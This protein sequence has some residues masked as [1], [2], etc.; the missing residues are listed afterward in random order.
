MVY[1]QATV[2]LLKNALYNYG[3]LSTI[4]AVYNDFFSYTGGV[5]HYVTGGL[6]GYHAVL[7]V[8][9]DDPG[10]YFIVKNSWGTWWGEAGYFK[11]AYSELDSVVGFGDYTI[12]YMGTAPTCSYSI[13]NLNPS[14]FP[15]AGGPGS[16]NVN[17]TTNCP[18][19]AS[20]NVSWIT[21]NSGAS[22]TGSGSVT[23]SV[24]QNT[25]DSRNGTLNI[26]GQTVHHRPGSRFAFLVPF[27]LARLSK[28]SVPPVGTEASG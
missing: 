3:P 19:T 28:A 9:Y 6:A 22:G 11:I 14:S 13:S 25:G 26:A 10:Q 27:L 12:A 17:A 20:S 1:G 8:G 16:V 7:L 18:W 24:S 21:I 4:F 5:Y 23:F 2:D 15:A